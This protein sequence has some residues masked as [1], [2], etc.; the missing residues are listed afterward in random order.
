MNRLADS[1]ISPGRSAYAR[2]D[3]RRLRVGPL[4]RH[5]HRPP[6]GFGR[7][8]RYA[9]FDYKGSN[10]FVSALGVASATARDGNPAPPT[11]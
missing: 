6:F 10:D 5:R 4:K 7:D 1:L 9:N 11:L 8:W 2:M 3:R